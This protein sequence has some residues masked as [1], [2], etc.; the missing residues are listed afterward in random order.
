[1][2]W[3]LSFQRLFLSYPLNDVYFGDK[4]YV[5]HELMRNKYEFLLST[6]HHSTLANWHFGRWSHSIRTASPWAIHSG[7]YEIWTAANCDSSGTPALLTEIYI[8]F[9][10]ICHG[11]GRLR[12]AG[13]ENHLSVL[14]MYVVERKALCLSVYVS[15][16]LFLPRNL[17]LN[18]HTRIVLLHRIA[19]SKSD[20]CLFAVAFQPT[21]KKPMH[22]II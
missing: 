4:N 11:S 12:H 18:S 22:L 9:W 3:S 6:D 14:K 7:D 20:Q 1:M 21:E 15:A 2:K 17:Q 16:L 19:P 5:G 8:Q 13:I 10:S